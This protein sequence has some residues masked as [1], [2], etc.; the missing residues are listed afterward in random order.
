[1]AEEK[2]QKNLA[3]LIRKAGKEQRTIEVQ[4]PLIKGFY[5]TISYASKFVMNQIREA[6]I[7]TETNLRT[8][9]VEESFDDEKLREQYS[10]HLLKDWRGLTG[11]KLKGIIPGF[12]VADEDA[13]KD[14]PF[15]R[16]IALSLMEVSVEFENWV[17]AT[18]TTVKN[19]TK[20]ALQKEAEMENLKN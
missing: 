3:E 6:A 4:F 12:E 1:M 7:V 11:E 16:E 14:I 19:Y 5:A 8:N 20:T 9:V 10:W 17:V 2:K 18:A 15:D 13:E